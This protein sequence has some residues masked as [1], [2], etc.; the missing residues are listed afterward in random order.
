MKRA[1]GWLFNN[2]AAQTKSLHAISPSLGNSSWSQILKATSVIRSDTGEFVSEARLCKAS[3]AA[4]I[5]LSFCDCQDHYNNHLGN[6][7]IFS[8]RSV[9]SLV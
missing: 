3:V 4:S 8:P 6:V 7:V 1:Q 5:P 9:F 2:W